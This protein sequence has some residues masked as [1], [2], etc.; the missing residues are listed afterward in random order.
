MVHKRRNVYELF[1]KGSMSTSNIPIVKFGFRKVWKSLDDA[2]VMGPNYLAPGFDNPKEL[3]TH[4]STHQAGLIICCLADKSDLLQIATLIKLLK[5]IDTAAKLVV[6][7]YSHNK[8]IDM[9]IHKLGVQDVIDPLMSAKILRFKIDLWLKS[10]TPKGKPVESGLTLKNADAKNLSDKKIDDKNYLILPPMACNDDMWLIHKDLECKKVLSRWLVRVLGPSPYV[11]LWVEAEGKSNVWRFNFHDGNEEDFISGAGHW[12]FRGDQKPEF[13]WKENIWYMT[14][15]NLDLFYYDSTVRSRLQLKDKVLSICANSP[16]ARAKEKLINESF[17]K[18]LVFKKGIE[19]H[20]LM[21]GQ[22]STEHLNQ[23]QLSNLAKENKSLPGSD[24]GG[25]LLGKLALEAEEVA[26]LKKSTDTKKEVELEL[27][28]KAAGVKNQAAL[29]G[30]LHGQAQLT[31]AQSGHLTGMLK[32]T[33]EKSSNRGKVS[34]L[35]PPTALTAAE[36]QSRASA[37]AAEAAAKVK[38]EENPE[39]PLSDLQ[40]K[41]KTDLLKQNNLTSKATLTK[42]KDLAANLSNSSKFKESELKDLTGKNKTD[43]LDHSDLTGKNKQSG[44][45]ASSPLILQLKEKAAKEAVAKKERSNKEIS[46]AS[47]LSGKTKTDHLDKNLSGKQKGEGDIGS[48]PLALLLR[49]EDRKPDN[50]DGDSTTDIL[51]NLGTKG[52][53]S[54]ELTKGSLLDY[55]NKKHTHETKYK[56][57]MLAEQFDAAPLKKKQFSQKEGAGLTGKNN[58]DRLKKHYNGKVNDDK[59]GEE[60]EALA[61]AALNGKNSQQTKPLVADTSGRS[62]GHRS[63]SDSANSL[64]Q[65]E[66]SLS[67]AANVLPFESNFVQAKTSDKKAFSDLT[68]QLD[69][70]PDPELAQALLGATVTTILHH[71]NKAISCQLDDFFDQQVFFRLPTSQLKLQESVLLDMT[72]DYLGKVSQL[73]LEGLITANESSEE[74]SFVTVALKEKE[75]SDF[76]AFMQLYRSRQQNV[77]VFLKRV[78]GF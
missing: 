59:S 27:A 15:E 69:Q 20:G 17:D 50:W 68:Q 5:K 64:T 63:N 13:N 2:L 35:P 9:A 73:K 1:N 48:D 38:R 21:E 70:E 33:A 26:R 44:V 71:Q 8:S 54:G 75:V 10:M 11:G 18:D 61:F 43:H 14:G 74:N 28:K 56:G 31:A 52:P 32:E 24:L 3:L 51:N 53:A 55:E 39:A 23:P 42:S 65:I 46:N 72:F 67:T 57:K 62:K 45:L 19:R 58:T 76:E 49:P 41:A 36:K 66:D 37:T 29:P 7:N 34:P 25:N 30:H 40:G 6:V 47:D 12:F 16:A 78:K 4:L 22:G 60:K 77:D